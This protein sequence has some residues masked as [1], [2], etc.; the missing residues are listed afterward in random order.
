MAEKL[1]EEYPDHPALDA[2]MCLRSNWEIHHEDE[3][4]SNNVDDNLELMK[5]NG[6]RS[7]HFTV[8]NPHPKERDDFGRF[9]S[10]S[11][12]SPNHD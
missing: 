8:N 9:K 2:K 1:Q 4:K 5:G 3:N 7:H 11:Y 12:K 10:D 6:H